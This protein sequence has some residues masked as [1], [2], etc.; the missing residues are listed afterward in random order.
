MRMNRRLGLYEEIT[1][2]PPQAAGWNVFANSKE[3]STDV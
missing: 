1:T 3:G 2:D